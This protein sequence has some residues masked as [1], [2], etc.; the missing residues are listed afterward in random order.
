MMKPFAAALTGGSGAIVGANTWS[1][2]LPES[3]NFF[4]AGGAIGFIMLTLL[5]FLV[6]RIAT[7]FM[8]SVLGGLMAS[9]GGL[10]LLLQVPGL[11]DSLITSI[12]GHN[13]VM[14]SVIGLAAV[15]AF[16]WQEV[17]SRNCQNV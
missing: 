17:S 8:V 16:V 14:P 2:F 9:V 13:F 15:G 3:S 10:S 4:W 6:F 11:G 12:N 5:S 7:V 1:A